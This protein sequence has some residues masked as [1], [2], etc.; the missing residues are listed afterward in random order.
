MPTAIR[1]SLVIPVY[2]E[3][4]SLNKLYER[5]SKVID[6]LDGPAEVILVDDG[7]RDRSFPMMRAIHERDPR[8]HAL[9][10]S[11]N[12]GHQMALTAGLDYARGEAIV[13]M[14]ADLQDPPEVIFDLVKKWQEG[15]ELVY[16]VRRSRDVDTI[17][18]KYSAIAF[19]HILRKLASIEAPVNSAD[20]RLVDRKVLLSFRK[21]REKNRYIRGL[22]SWLGYRQA[23]VYYD[24]EARF[25][26][27]TKYPFLKMLNLAF[28]AIVSFSSIPLKL[29]VSVGLAVA[30]ISFL[31]GTWIIIAKTLSLETY[32]SG[33]ATLAVLMCFLGGLHMFLIGV[34][35]EYLSRVYDEVRGRP[36]YL[37][38][39]ILSDRALSNERTTN[40]EEN[41]SVPLMRDY[42][43]SH[44][45]QDFA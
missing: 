37:V 12:F 38:S 22:F 6:Q 9:S 26:G 15:N 1:Y 44:L 30:F 35:G 24:R 4:E 25:A 17:F 2:N 36:L 23:E 28:D 10:L 32:I 29:C 34:L 45:P 5:V 43:K 42:P 14:D 16:A 20:F 27:E 21:L 11:R 31:Y 8:F 18:K 19:Y 41:L 3:E 33:W 13:T 7:S 40:P 39:Q